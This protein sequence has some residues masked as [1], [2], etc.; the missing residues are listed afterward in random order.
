MGAA[1][2]RVPTG[3]LKPLA[4]HVEGCWAFAPLATGVR[5]TW[6]W[7]LH[8]TS[9]YAARVLPVVG[10]MWLGYARQALEQTSG[11]LLR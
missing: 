11:A 2:D 7:V 6:S 8:P 10:R 3:A 1:F 9:A 5:V 4:S